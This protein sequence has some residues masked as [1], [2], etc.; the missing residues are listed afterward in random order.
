[1]KLVKLCSGILA[2]AAISLNSCKKEELSGNTTFAYEFQAETSLLSIF[3]EIPQ[4]NQ[5]MATRGIDWTTATLNLARAELT[6]KKESGEEVQA[7][8]ENLSNINLLTPGKYFGEIS[9]PKAA[10]SSVQVKLIMKKS[11]GADIPLTL[12]AKLTSS[13][14]NQ[15][16]VEFYF[17][18]DA[19]LTVQTN[20]LEAKGD[21]YIGQ[22][23]LQLITFL[24]Q[25][26][27]SQISTAERT[28]GVIIISNTSNTQLYDLAK[29]AL[30][31]S[32]TLKIARK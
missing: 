7:S 14:G 1:M 4:A 8:A 31:S 24:S 21:R 28:N 18:D 26:D 3:S 20:A 16:P 11:S 10:Y 12:K 15:V 25:I 17:N 29:T 6:A 2:I 13:S 32:Y 9:I 23:R 19:Q 27:L 22:I 30:S 5:V